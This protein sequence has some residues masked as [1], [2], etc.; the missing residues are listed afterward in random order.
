MSKTHS[1]SAHLAYVPFLPTSYPYATHAAKLSFLS[2]ELPYDYEDIEDD[3][4]DHTQGRKLTSLEADGPGYYDDAAIEKTVRFDPSEGLIHLPLSQVF[5]PLSFSQVSCCLSLTLAFLISGNIL[6]DELLY[7]YDDAG[8]PLENSTIGSGARL[9]GGS[10]SCSGRLE[11]LD[12]YSWKSICDTN[13]NQMAAEVV[14]RELDC[15]APKKYQGG[16]FGQ[17][18]G[19]VWEKKIQCRGSE[20]KIFDCSTVNSAAGHCTKRN[21][22][23][24][25]CVPYRLVSGSDSECSGRVELYYDRRWG[26]VCDRYWDLQDAS[27]LCNQIGCGYAIEAPG[28]ASLEKAKEKY[29]EIIFTVREMRLT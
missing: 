8:E 6:H 28:Q 18:S 4:Q 26:T 29:G 5:S 1:Y 23:G 21:D 7:S 15:G 9:V 13:F 27:V 24:L 14:C 25:V 2:D 20:R 12:G 22:V 11:M 10:S 16:M 17:G 3:D 19:S